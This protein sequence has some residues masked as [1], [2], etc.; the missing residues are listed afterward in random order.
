MVDS[1]V[2]TAKLVQILHFVKNVTKKIQSMFIDSKNKKFPKKIILHR[3]QMS[4]LQKATC[5]VQYAKNVFLILIK[6]FTSVGHVHL[7]LKRLEMLF[8]G[9]KFVKIKMIINIKEKSL[10]DYQDWCN[11]M[12]KKITKVNHISTL[13]CKNT[14]IWIAKILLEVAN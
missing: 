2:L 7:I 8:I 14:T 6:E 4:W 12:K 13:Y 3:M 10:K 9:A 11:K 5:F 1:I